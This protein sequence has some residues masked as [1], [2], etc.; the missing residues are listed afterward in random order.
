MK[1]EKTQIVRLFTLCT[2]TRR[3]FPPEHK[4]YNTII[5]AH[6]EEEVEQNKNKEKRRKEERRKK[7]LPRSRHQGFRIDISDKGW[8]RSFFFCIDIIGTPRTYVT[9]YM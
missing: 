1:R 8:T 9:S 3:F 2:G 6:G 5:T 4:S 7:G